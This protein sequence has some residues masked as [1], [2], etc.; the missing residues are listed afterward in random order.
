MVEKLKHYAIVIIIEKGAIIVIRLK[1]KDPKQTSRQLSLLGYSVN[2]FARAINSNP[3]Y[4]GKVLAGKRHPYPPLA[5][6]I[7]LGLG[8]EIK[9]IFLV[10]DA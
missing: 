7:A 3:G 10:D 9:D 2:G 8:V 1:L 5:K 6:K 4:I